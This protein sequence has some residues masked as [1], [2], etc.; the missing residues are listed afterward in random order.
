MLTD[1]HKSFNEIRRMY[2]DEYIGVTDAV[3]KP[4]NKGV[5]TFYGVIVCTGATED[6]VYNKMKD[7]NCIAILSGV[8]LLNVERIGLSVINA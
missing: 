4:D 8:N 5:L 6:D 1:K 7:L 3:E 2:P